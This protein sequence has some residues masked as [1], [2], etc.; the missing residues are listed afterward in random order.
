MKTK[1]VEVN[2]FHRIDLF[3]VL[4]DFIYF[5]DSCNCILVCLDIC[6]INI[7]KRPKLE[8]GIQYGRKYH[9]EMIFSIEDKTLCNQTC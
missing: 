1:E 3:S 6:M 5:Y 9:I 2:E 4:C 7:E 8:N